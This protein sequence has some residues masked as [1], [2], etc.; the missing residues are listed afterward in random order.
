MGRLRLDGRVAVITGAGA[1]QGRETALLFAAEGAR[2]VAADLRGEAARETAELICAAG[3]QALG[4]A[5]DVA[6]DDAN[7]A[8]VQSAVRTYGRLDVF[9]ANAGMVARGPGGDVGLEEIAVETWNRILAVNLTGAFLGCRHAIPEIVRSGGGSVILTASVGA[10][11]GQRAHNHAYVA[12]KTALVGLARNLAV[13]YAP[14]GVRVNCLCPGQIR[15]DMM[16]DFYDDPEKRRRFE[17]LT[18]VGRFGE[19]REVA[20]VALFLASD[21]SA[22]MTGSVVTVDGGWTAL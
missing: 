15:T 16:A 4:V 20:S 12:S 9:H 5:C 18:P 3:G 6:D 11:V 21:D 17:E 2:V 19:P 22:F 8:A 7:R 10:L 13:E 1:G 14:R